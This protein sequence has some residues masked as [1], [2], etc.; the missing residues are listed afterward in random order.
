MPESIR[1]VFGEEC[2]GLHIDAK[3]LKRLHAYQVG[4]V[5]KNDDHIVFFGGHLLGVQVVRFTPAD[6]DRWFDEILEV[7][8]VPLES[9]LLALPDVNENFIVSSNTMNLSCAWLTHAICTSKHLSDEQKREGMIDTLLVLQYKFLTSLLYNLFRYPAD[10]AVAEATYAQLSYKFAIKQYGNWYALLRARAEAVID[11]ESIHYNTIAKMDKDL[12]VTYLLSD[13][14]GRIRDLLK[15]IYG[16]FMSVHKQGIKIS[17]TSGV[18][19]HDGQ[20]ILKDKTKSVT[21][22]GRY[23]NSIVTDKQTFMREELL[24]IIEKLMHTMPP[25][26]FRQTLAWMSDNYRQQGAGEIEEVL[27]EV[28][29]HSFEYLSS[30]RSLI[31]NEHDLPGLLSRLRGVYMS[32]RSTD[33]SVLTLRSKTEA[34]V[35]HAT[36]NKNTSIIA[37]VRTGVL[38]Y[39]IC[40]A[41]TMHHYAG[42]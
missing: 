15:N 34:M 11:K 6:Q 7:D 22:Y 19:E 9:R 37:S 24:V 14:Q 17:S 28:L 10:P 4:F 30:N 33:E 1:S 16:V 31:K 36:H 21:A 40:R 3:L 26:L 18:V 29:I 13:T 12:D 2:H 25:K 23:L 8:P 41:Y 35:E 20:E 27:N 39:L 32:S 42:A 38:L 5:N